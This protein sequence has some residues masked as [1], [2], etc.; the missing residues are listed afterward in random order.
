MPTC[1]RRRLP[2]AGY[3]RRSPGAIREAYRPQRLLLVL[4]IRGGVG[5]VCGVTKAMCVGSTVPEAAAR[6]TTLCT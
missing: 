2:G 3:V 6:F 1:P 4:L 5:S